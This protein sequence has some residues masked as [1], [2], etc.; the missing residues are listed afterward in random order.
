MK[1]DDANK[2]IPLIQFN[3]IIVAEEYKISLPIRPENP[4]LSRPIQQGQSS[5]KR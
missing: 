5:K 1:G 4:I 2:I 3:M